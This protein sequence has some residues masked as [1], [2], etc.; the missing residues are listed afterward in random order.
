MLGGQAHFVIGRATEIEQLQALTE[1]IWLRRGADAATAKRLA[2]RVGLL[3]EP[4]KLSS[5]NTDAFLSTY[6]NEITR[7][8]GGA[9]V[10][11]EALG[12]F[13][14][15]INT[16]VNGQDWLQASGDEWVATFDRFARKPSDTD[17]TMAERVEDYVKQL[18]RGVVEASKLIT[19]RALKDELDML[20]KAIMVK[21]GQLSYDFKR[22][23]GATT[24]GQHAAFDY[25]EPGDA[26]V[27]AD[28]RLV[29]AISRGILRS[30]LSG[31]A[32]PEYAQALL[33]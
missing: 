10:P 16:R 4:E 7:A 28:Y 2:S 33:G 6:I 25:G 26:V 19:D 12:T 29:G 9:G 32:V 1:E 5:R 23:L 18:R 3:M 21:D 27:K 17:A 31:E 22:F 8:L 20:S 30:V 13:I 14:K 15:R 11:A 24:I